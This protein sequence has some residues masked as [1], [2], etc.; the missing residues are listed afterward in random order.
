MVK[1]AILK[2]S[3]GIFLKNKFLSINQGWK[4]KARPWITF[5]CLNV[6]LCDPQDLMMN[7]R[8]PDKIPVS[9]RRENCAGNKV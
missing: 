6:L 4:M 5:K 7:R 8:K 2:H 1:N 9:V 3:E